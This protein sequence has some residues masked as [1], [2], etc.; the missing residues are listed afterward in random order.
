MED[1]LDLVSQL[2]RE[3]RI[4]QTHSLNCISPDDGKYSKS[5]RKL[6]PYL[7]AAA[8]WMACVLVQ[9]ALLETRVEFGQA[10][11]E[12]LDEVKAAF[13]FVSPLNMAL[14]EEKVT[15]HD[16]LAVLEE[17]GRYVRPE[18]KALLHPGTTSYD[19][20]DTARS[21]LVK[22][23]WR[24]EIRPTISKAIDKLCGVAENSLDILQVGRTHLQH[25]SPITFGSMIAGYAARLASRLERCDEYIDDLRGKI[26]GIVGTGASIAMVI[27]DGTSIEFEKA[28]LE[29]LGLAERVRVI[30]PTSD[31]GYHLIR[32]VG[33][34]MVAK[35]WAA[36]VFCDFLKDTL[37][38]IRPEEEIPGSAQQVFDC[39]LITSDTCR[40]I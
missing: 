22:K 30:S 7:S 4:L 36:T 32:D 38:D 12:R 29:K 10:E 2:T 11:K 9:E 31:T 16:Q 34:A 40:Q 18:T 25:T 23:A 15:R 21:Y 3:E 5:S 8:E 24:E 28:V 20:L 39:Y 33:P 6:Q 26:S 1:K 27:G 13:E 35:T 17:I 37:L 14:L 19:I